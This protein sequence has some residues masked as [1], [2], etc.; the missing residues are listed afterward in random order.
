MVTTQLMLFVPL[1]GGIKLSEMRWLVIFED[2]M[3]VRMVS[4]GRISE[5]KNDG[6]IKR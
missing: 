4:H 5:R 6:I 2:F 3:V 1:S